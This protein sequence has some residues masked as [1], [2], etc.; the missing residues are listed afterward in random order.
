VIGT[1]TIDQYGV[2]ITKMS[3]GYNRVYR[4]SGFDTNMLTI[5][6]VCQGDLKL[7]ENIE[8]HP[9][10]SIVCN[11]ESEKNI[12]IYFTDGESPIKIL[13]IMDQKYSEGSDL[14]D[15]EGNIINPEAIDMTPSAEL[16][17]P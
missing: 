4:I 10:I 15:D 9:N 6:V 1:A 8:K 17:P 5:Q 16:P 12:K 3:N 7:S 2:V 14:V 13:N 11:Y